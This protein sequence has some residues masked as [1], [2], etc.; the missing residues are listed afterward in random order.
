MPHTFKI[1]K[2]AEKNLQIDL[3]LPSIAQLA[4]MTDEERR[5]LLKKLADKIALLS[6][7]EIR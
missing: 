7:D 5:L 4:I 2:Q 3:M 6:K 1:P